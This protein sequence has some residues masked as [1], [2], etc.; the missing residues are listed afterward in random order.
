MATIRRLDSGHLTCLP[1]SVG[2]RRLCDS[3]GALGLCDIA[4][5]SEI[6]VSSCTD[7]IFTL[8]FFS[9][10]G[11]S[12]RQFNTLRLG[13]AWGERVSVG[14]HVRL[15]D[16]KGEHIDYRK[17]LDVKVGPKE[18]IIREFAKQNHLLAESDV[19]NEE[20]GDWMIKQMPNLYGNLIYKNNAL[21]TAI[22][23]GRVR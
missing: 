23:L 2:E 22:T 10:K 13:K 15:V 12:S 19:T 16:V 14:S 7:Y 21:C 9:T 20:A 1:K 5:K 3:C 8:R 4:E 6:I 11:L 18:Q 17:V